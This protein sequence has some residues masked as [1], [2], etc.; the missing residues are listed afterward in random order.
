MGNAAHKSKEERRCT[1]A[2]AAID[3]VDIAEY[4]FLPNAK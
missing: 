4:K 3:K 1:N 2:A